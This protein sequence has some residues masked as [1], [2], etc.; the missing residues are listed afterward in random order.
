MTPE[1]MYKFGKT[2]FADINARFSEA[3]HSQFKWRSIP[4]G[5]DYDIKPLWSRWVTKE[6][7]VEAEKWFKETYP[8]DFFTSKNYNG[9]GECRVWK[10]EESYAF[11]GLLQKKYPKNFEY[12]K[13]ISK[14]EEAGILK[15]ICDKI[16][17]IMLTKR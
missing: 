9:I 16:Y 1:R 12:T 15:S 4:L 8:K 14:F 3:V 11:M 17:Y 13:A 5:S 7:A 6:E 10:L 2:N